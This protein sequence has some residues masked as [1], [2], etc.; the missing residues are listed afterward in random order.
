MNSPDPTLVEAEKSTKNPLSPPRVASAPDA[1]LSEEDAEEEKRRTEA[2]QQQLDDFWCDVEL[3]VESTETGSMLRDMAQI[4]IPT[5]RATVPSKTDD[6]VTITSDSTYACT[7]VVV[8]DGDT[9]TYIR[10]DDVTHGSSGNVRT[11]CLCTII[12]PFRCHAFSLSAPLCVQ[13]QYGLAFFQSLST[14]MY[15]LLDKYEQYQHYLEYIAFVDLNPPT[16]Q[17]GQDLFLTPT[18]STTVLTA[19]HRS[20]YVLNP[21]SQPNVYRALTMTA[22]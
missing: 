4:E 9:P 7:Y 10:T 5:P 8:S 6:K 14:A 1:Q 16:L 20:E 12:I 21:T 2:V 18:P 13:E 22:K 11:M 3:L 15:N 19:S 17:Q